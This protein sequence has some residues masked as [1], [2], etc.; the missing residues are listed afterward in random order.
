M[1]PFFVKNV[2]RILHEKI[3]RVK[4]FLI[5]AEQLRQFIFYHGN[6]KALHTFFA[7]PKESMQR[8]GVDPLILHHAK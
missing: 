1:I 8:K 7:A 6:L 2:E 4:K 3:L 5:T